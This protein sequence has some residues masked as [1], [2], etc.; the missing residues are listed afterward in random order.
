MGSEIPDT[1]VIFP[2]FIIILGI[3]IEIPDTL[4]IFPIF[5]NILENTVEIPDTLVI[6]HVIPTFTYSSSSS[7]IPELRSR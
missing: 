4:L 2:I 7:G 1:F 6:F 5:I 3:T